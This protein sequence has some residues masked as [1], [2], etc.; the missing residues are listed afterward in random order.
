MIF[1]LKT[2]AVTSLIDKTVLADTRVLDKHL[3]ETL[4]E[5][6]IPRLGTFPKDPDTLQGPFTENFRVGFFLAKSIS[7]N[8]VQKIKIRYL[9]TLER[10]LP[11]LDNPKRSLKVFKDIQVGPGRLAK[12]CVK[13]KSLFGLNTSEVKVTIRD[14]ILDHKEVFRLIGDVLNGYNLQNMVF[15]DARM[16]FFFQRANEYLSGKLLDF[17]PTW[18]YG[19]EL[20]NYIERCYNTII[21]NIVNDVENTSDNIWRNAQVEYYAVEKWFLCPCGFIQESHDDWLSHGFC[22]THLD[23]F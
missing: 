19:D 20:E 7:F 22:I 1:S 21:A 6:K 9:G 16:F 12:C 2:C 10:T 15:E 11:A 3:D 23:G 17:L 13:I 4:I 5:S 18:T 8:E 14:A